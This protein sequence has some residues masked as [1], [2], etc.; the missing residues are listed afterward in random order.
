MLS[1]PRRREEPQILTFVSAPDLHWFAQRS[2][3]RAPAVSHTPVTHPAS[4]GK[5]AA[6]T[7]STLLALTEALLAP[8]AQ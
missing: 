7:T 1:A 2:G 6:K 3:T 8:R 5:S 4:D